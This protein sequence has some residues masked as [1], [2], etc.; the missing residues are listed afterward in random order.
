MADLWVQIWF[1]GWVLSFLAAVVP[2][3]WQLWGRGDG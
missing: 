1:I 3:L 2:T